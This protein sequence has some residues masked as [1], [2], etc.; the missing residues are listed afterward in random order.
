[1]GQLKRLSLSQQ[2]EKIGVFAIDERIV[3]VSFWGG[4]NGFGL[5]FTF[6][7]GSVGVLTL[8][9]VTGQMSVTRR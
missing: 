5:T 6:S 4:I 3:S 1:M 7:D 2:S 9:G 8:N